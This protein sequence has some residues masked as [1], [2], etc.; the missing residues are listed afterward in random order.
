MYSDRLMKCFFSIY[1][2]TILD[3]INISGISGF[4]LNSYS[5]T[6]NSTRLRRQAKEC[7]GYTCTTTGKCINEE[8]RCD[9]TVDCDDGSDEFNDC[10]DVISCPG[11]LFT[12]DY[13]ACIDEDKKCDGKKDC[14]DNSDEA[15]CIAGQGEVAKVEN[16]CKSDQ[17]QCDSGQ[18]ISLDD[19][20]NGQTDCQD[21]SD[22]TKETCLNIYCPGFT[23]KCDY[24]ACV[25]GYAECN[26]VRDCVDNS[27][28]LDCL[29]PTTTTTKKPPKGTPRPPPDTPSIGVCQLP[30]YPG[31]GKWAIQGGTSLSPGQRVGVNTLLLFSCNPGYQLSRENK[32]LGCFEGGWNLDPPTC[33]QLCPALYETTV[34]KVRCFDEKNNEVRCDQATSGA[35]AKFECATYYESADRQSAR[36]YCWSGLW[37]LP[38]PQCIPVCGEK[39]VSAEPLIVNGLTVEKGDYPWVTAIFQDV[40]SEVI[41]VCG[42]SM[43]TQKVIITAAHCVANGYGNALEAA[44]IKVAV[45]DI[46]VHERYKGDSQRY[47]SDIAFLITKDTLLLS[48]VVQPVCVS[49]LPNIHLSSRSEGVITG[50]GYT[51]AGQGP[52]E[53]LKEISV[54]FKDDATCNTELPPDWIDKYYSYDKFCAGHYNKSIAVCKGDSGGGLVFKNPKDERY[55]IHGLVSVG[56]KVNNVGCDIQVSALYT[57]VAVHYEW[58]EQVTS[59]YTRPPS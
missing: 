45:Q 54:P 52:S 53:E 28:E 57:K 58:L 56:R 16:N 38:P 8:S 34:T 1:V 20:C 9:G 48:K 3:V 29:P 13:G 27:D 6:T 42:G 24:G 2:L 59:K 25:D 39:K 32:L 40:G 5:V 18:C 43:L 23:F 17:F 37:N 21:K 31:N 35:T 50:W 12:C 26:G 33:L 55:Y 22:E 4:S 49:D 10:K 19:K 51:S 30:E 14:R 36:R 44:K 11:Y 46:L 41:N 47:A 7:D 15:H